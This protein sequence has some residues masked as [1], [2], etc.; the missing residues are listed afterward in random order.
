MKNGLIPTFLGIRGP[1]SQDPST[2]TGNPGAEQ[3]VQIRPPPSTGALVRSLMMGRGYLSETDNSLQSHNPSSSDPTSS[4]LQKLSQGGGFQV[5]IKKVAKKKNLFRFLLAK[6]LYEED[7]LHLDEYLVLWELFYDLSGLLSK[8]PGFRLKYETSIFEIT[9]FFEAIGPR[10]EFPLRFKVKAPEM[11]D[12][13][14]RMQ[15]LLP[16]KSA[17]YGLKGQKD[18]RL[19]FSIVFNLD[20]PETKPKEA[21]VIGVG[22]RDHGTKKP[23]HEGSPHFSEVAMHFQE[24]EVRTEEELQGLSRD[25]PEF[26]WNRLW[27]SQEP[28]KSEKKYNTGL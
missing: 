21:R 20:L 11:A 26:A 13:C 10:M 25:D 28:P 8:D 5:K 4:I 27:G 2:D 16:S 9:S 3:E 1:R 7:G 18:L 14:Q 15:P 23:D 6:T 12:L 19:G 22:Y 17:F 24:L